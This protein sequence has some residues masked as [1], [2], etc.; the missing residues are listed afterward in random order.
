MTY[1]KDINVGDLVYT[2]ESVYHWINGHRQRLTMIDDEG[3]EWHRYDKPGIEYHVDTWAVKGKVVTTFEGELPDDEKISDY[4]D[5]I[6]LEN[7]KTKERNT[8]VGVCGNPLENVYLCSGDAQSAK[9][10]ATKR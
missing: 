10:T 6:F 4:T 9:D 1:A 7:V 5:S 8:L 3:N 2:V